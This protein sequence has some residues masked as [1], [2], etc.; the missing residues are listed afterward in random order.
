M[1]S[2]ISSS[3]YKGTGSI[4][5]RPRPYDLIYIKL[6]VKGPVF[7]TITLRVWDQHMNFGDAQ[8]TQYASKFGKLSSGHRTGKDQF[9]FKPKERQYQRMFKLLQDCTHITH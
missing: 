9:S 1:I 8:F 2:D 4:G 5:L 7:K 3:S 6:S